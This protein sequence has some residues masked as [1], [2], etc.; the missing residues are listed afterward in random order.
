MDYPSTNNF[1]EPVFT[2]RSY[3]PNPITNNNVAAF[4]NPALDAEA[5]RAHDL[6]TTDPAG[7]TRL[8]GAIDREITDKALWVPL[9]V[10]LVPDLVS[11]RTG[12]Y[13]HCF[14]SYGA[15]GA[16]LDQLWVR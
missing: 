6:Q 15:S 2:C 4:C 10:D 1:F 7:A 11:R 12:N 8:W 14:L 5:A 9:R 13:I 3:T 16:C